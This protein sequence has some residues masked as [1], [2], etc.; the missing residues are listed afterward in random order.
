MLL[1]PS[2]NARYG[3]TGG[4]T[5][6]SRDLASRGTWQIARGTGVTGEAVAASEG[7]MGGR[8]R[9]AACV[10]ASTSGTHVSRLTGRPAKC[11]TPANSRQLAEE[12]RGRGSTSAMPVSGRFDTDNAVD[13]S[14]P[15]R[16]SLS[17]NEGDG[18]L[19]SQ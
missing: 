14:D 1:P 5:F 15:L 7:G 17:R 10:K 11:E 18:Q 6:I 12:H 19:S 13:H 16:G 9:Q 4:G 3:A 8:A 2:L